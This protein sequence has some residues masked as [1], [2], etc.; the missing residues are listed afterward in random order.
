MTRIKGAVVTVV[1]MGVAVTI[2]LGGCGGQ[3]IDPDNTDPRK[4]PVYVN[5]NGDYKYCDGSTLVY[6]FYESGSTIANSQEC[7]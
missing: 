5:D 2:G 1:S 6:R 7:A 3:R 4:G